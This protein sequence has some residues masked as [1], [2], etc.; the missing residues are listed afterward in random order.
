[1]DITR[2]IAAEL[3]SATEHHTNRLKFWL[4][5]KELFQPILD[6]LPQ[7][8]ILSVCPTTYNLDISV[9]GNKDTFLAVWKVLRA[10]GY[11]HS[12][13]VDEKFATWDGFFRHDSENTDE[14]PNIWVSFSSTICKR[15]K[16]GTKMEEVPVYEIQCDG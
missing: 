11:D 14:F 10:A 6:E 15:V 9:T 16:V 4:K 8:S 2:E 5:H 13:I 7:D 12:K 3:A 1:M